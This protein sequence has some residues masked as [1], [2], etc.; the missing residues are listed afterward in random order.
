[1]SISRRVSFMY[2]VSLS[3]AAVLFAHQYQDQGTHARTRTNAWFVSE[4]KDFNHP[5]APQ[6]GLAVPLSNNTRLATRTRRDKQVLL[7]SSAT[8]FNCRSMSVATPTRIITTHT[9]TARF[10]VSHC[11]RRTASFVCSC[12]TP[13][14]HERQYNAHTTAC[15]HGGT[16][17]TQQQLLMGGLSLRHTYIMHTRRIRWHGRLKQT[18]RQRQSPL[19]GWVV[20]TSS[21]WFK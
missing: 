2:C 21:T 11:R 17:C 10:R 7:L 15:T 19:G 18:C 13:V 3:M 9:G 4:T 5:P 1:M 14:E 12:D 20:V 8:I 6:P 16:R